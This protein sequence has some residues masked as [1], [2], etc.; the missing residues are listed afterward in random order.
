[1]DTLQ[2]LHNLD[3][4]L[5]PPSTMS[6]NKNAWCFMHPFSHR[7]NVLMLIP[8]EL[9]DFEENWK[10][11][12]NLSGWEDRLHMNGNRG[13]HCLGFPFYFVMQNIVEK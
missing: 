5:F 10:G 13:K 9:A 4:G 1:M 2:T 6:T 11:K 3:E 8:D 12:G 7:T